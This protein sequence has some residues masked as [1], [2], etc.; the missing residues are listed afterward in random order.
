MES[1]I[2]DLSRPVSPDEAV[3]TVPSAATST[4]ITS[5]AFAQQW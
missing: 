4:S 1:E 2:I 5:L 3:D